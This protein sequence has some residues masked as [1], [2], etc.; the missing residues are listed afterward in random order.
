M[1]G[2]PHLRT[3][4]GWPDVSRSPFGLP[5][6]YARWSGPE[7]DDRDLLPA[8]QVEA[9]DG[10]RHVVG[11]NRTG[12]SSSKSAVIATPAAGAVAEGDDAGGHIDRPARELLHAVLVDAHR[13][14]DRL[15]DRAHLDDA[16]RGIALDQLEGLVAP[17]PVPISWPVAL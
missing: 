15:G 9:L 10:H 13:P 17:S 11:A 14:G 7:L 8:V 2:V 5:L 4:C 1:A 3:N 16:A 6:R 12:T